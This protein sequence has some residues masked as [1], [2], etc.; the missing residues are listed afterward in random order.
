L[1]FNF[2]T[3]YTWLILFSNQN[4]AN[5]YRHASNGHRIPISRG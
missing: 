3:F 1:A 2:N 4:L 5:R